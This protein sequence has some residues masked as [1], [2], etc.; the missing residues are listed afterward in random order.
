MMYKILSGVREG[1]G[2]PQ[3]APGHLQGGVR[4]GARDP[5]PLPPSAEPFIYASAVYP[6]ALR[7]RAVASTRLIFG[8]VIYIYIYISIYI[9]ICIYIYIERERY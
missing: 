3:R 1:A 7:R 5:L 8:S 4:A 2:G 9:Y 6:R